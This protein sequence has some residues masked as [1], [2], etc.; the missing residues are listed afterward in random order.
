MAQR[1]LTDFVG[2]VYDP[3]SEFSGG[4]VVDRRDVR[5]ALTE[6]YQ[7]ASEAGGRKDGPGREKNLAAMQVYRDVL[8]ALQDGKDLADIKADAA[9]RAN[10]SA[11]ALDDATTDLEDAKARGQQQAAED[12]VDIIAREI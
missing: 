6:K 5:D 11:D 1:A 7:F 8:G 10:R 12:V 4:D 9:I 3:T 2:D